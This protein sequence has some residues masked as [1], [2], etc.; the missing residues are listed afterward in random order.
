MNILITGAKGM[1][2]FALVKKLSSN[3]KIFPFDIDT[4]DITN[5]QECLNVVKINRPD[6]IIHCAS[7]T[8]VDG[9]ETNIEKAFA[10]NALGTKNIALVCQKLDIPMIYI[11]TDYIFDGTKNEPYLESDTPSPVSVYGKSKY[12]GEKAV[13]DTIKKFYIIRT[14][15]LYGPSGKNFVNTIIK[16]AKEKNELRVVNDQSGSPTYTFDLADAISQLIQK[17]FYGV[18]HITNQGHCSWYEFTKIILEAA[19]IKNKTV[20]PVT[21]DEF[22]RPA[23]RPKYSVLENRLFKLNGFT[24]PRHYKDAVEEYLK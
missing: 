9:C 4:M 22:P 10:V 23:P 5:Y 15:W 24:L 19:N 14:S 6:I 16:L 21:T 2:G 20:V 7:Y 11:S 3:N 1:L 13:Q 12:E 17:P 8:D 18:Y